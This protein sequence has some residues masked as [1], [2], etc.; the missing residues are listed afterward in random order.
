MTIDGAIA[1]AGSGSVLLAGG[2]TV[3]L[4]AAGSYAGG[5]SMVSGETLDLG[6]TGAAGSA[7]ITLGGDATVR[8]EAGVALDNDIIGFDTGETLDFVGI[9]NGTLAGTID[10]NVLRKLL[11]VG[12]SSGTVTVQF[13]LVAQFDTLDFHATL[14]AGVA[15]RVSPMSRVSRPERASI[16]RSVRDRS[17]CCASAIW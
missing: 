12:G 4:D 15:A 1:D 13:D 17:S 3:R 6:A 7:P 14:D 16:P 5:T 11:T 10:F 8:I 2:G 9:S